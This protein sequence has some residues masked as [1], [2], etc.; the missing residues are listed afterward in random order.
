MLLC[1]LAKSSKMF[2]MKRVYS[3]I[4]FNFL[5][6]QTHVVDFWE[7][8]VTFSAWCFAGASNDAMTTFC[9]FPYFCLFIFGQVIRLR[10]SFTANPFPS[11]MTMIQVDWSDHF[12]FISQCLFGKAEQKDL[13]PNGSFSIWSV[14]PVRHHDDHP[15]P[16][17]WLG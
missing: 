13:L 16:E 4:V 8:E 2:V 6:L 5:S 1:K 11:I 10:S 15:N 14:N 17:L 3:T 7:L 9:S 12:F